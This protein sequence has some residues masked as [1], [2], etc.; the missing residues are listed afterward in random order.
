MKVLSGKSMHTIACLIRNKHVINCSVVEN[1][2]TWKMEKTNKEERNGKKIFQLKKK[3]QN[4]PIF[5]GLIHETKNL[6]AQ[7]SLK[8]YILP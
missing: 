6:I 7:G 2:V 1:G 3:F 8:I 5:Q 4:I